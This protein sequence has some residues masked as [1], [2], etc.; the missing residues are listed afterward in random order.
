MYVRD[1][2]KILKYKKHDEFLRDYCIFAPTKVFKGE[3]IC[4]DCKGS[5]IYID[6]KNIDNLL[7][8]DINEL[9]I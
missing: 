2:T 4:K 3:R 8:Y 6:P 9:H 7:L 1:K 5:G